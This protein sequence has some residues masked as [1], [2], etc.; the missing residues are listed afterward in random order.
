M[1]H[2]AGEYAGRCGRGASAVFSLTLH[3]LRRATLE[4]LRRGVAG[5]THDL[6][7]LRPPWESDEVD[8][9]VRSHPNDAPR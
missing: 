1:G 5:E 7:G 9:G 3:G 2:C 6:E 4:D 8:S